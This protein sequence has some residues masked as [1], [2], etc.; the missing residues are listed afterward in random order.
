VPY[1]GADALF[2]EPSKI[3]MKKAAYFY[4]IKV[5]ERERAR[6]RGRELSAARDD[7]RRWQPSAPRASLWV[8]TEL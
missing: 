5:R 4:G 7:G 8:L 6:E 2:Y 3:D 1:T